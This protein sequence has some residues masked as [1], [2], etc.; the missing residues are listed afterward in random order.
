VPV[1][2]WSVHDWGLTPIVQASTLTVASGENSDHGN[3]A[4]A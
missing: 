4:A 3:R 2:N 1:S